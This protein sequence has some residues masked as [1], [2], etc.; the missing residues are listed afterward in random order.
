M[1]VCVWGLRDC[2]L[3]HKERKNEMCHMKV[4]NPTQ[5]ERKKDERWKRMLKTKKKFNEKKI[6]HFYKD[7]RFDYVFKRSCSLDDSSLVE[8][9]DSR[10]FTLGLH[11]KT[12][13]YQNH[14]NMRFAGFFLYIKVYNF[15]TQKSLQK[16]SKI[17]E[18]C[19]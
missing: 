19:V 17:L 6:I 11:H 2:Y 5:I 12:C 9:L 8:V 14:Y 10:F 4:Y 18:N 7:S 15:W 3:Y 1:C 16:V 13:L